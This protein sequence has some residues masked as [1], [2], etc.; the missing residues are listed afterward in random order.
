MADITKAIGSNDI[1]N[2]SSISGVNMRG[3]MQ[4]HFQEHDVNTPSLS[5]IE[6]KY[7]SR[8]DDPKYYGGQNSLLTGLV[9]WWKLNEVSGVRRSSF[10]DGVDLTDNNTVISDDEGVIE[11]CAQIVR[12]NAEYLD[13]DAAQVDDHF[14]LDSFSISIWFKMADLTNNMDIVRMWSGAGDNKFRTYFRED[15]QE[16]RFYHVQEP[17]TGALYIAH[18]GP[19]GVY[20]TDT[21][22]HLILVMDS[23]AGTKSIYVNADSGVTQTG[24]SI[25]DDVS[26]GMQFGWG[27]LF[28]GAF[29]EIA[30]WSKALSSDERTALYNDGNGITY[31]GF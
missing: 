13:V 15:A 10:G 12:A 22:Y 28:D 26:S 17:S 5:D 6:D 19:G 29:D 4:V 16:I 9:A 3:D 2:G 21:W 24:T 14:D 18:S 30:F 23:D 7:N 11:N 25:R 8:F 20:A 1:K 27:A 31:P